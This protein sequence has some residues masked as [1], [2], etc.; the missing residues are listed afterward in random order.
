MN[1][2]A[3][4]QFAA[5][6]FVALLFAA[7][8]FAQT[9]ELHPGTLQ[10]TVSF[11]G[12]TVTRGWLNVYATDASLSGSGSY[13]GSSYSLT[14]EGDHTYRPS[15]INAQFGSNAYLN[16][17]GNSQIA[18]VPVG[19]TA[20]LDLSYT[21]GR[22]ATSI[23]VIGGQLS[24]VQLHAIANTTT[25]SYEAYANYGSNSTSMYIPMV[26]GTQV[27]VVG[28]AYVTPTGSTAAVAQ[29][30]DPQT[31]SLTTAGAAL[32]W[33]VD[34]N[35]AKTGI[36]GS[37]AIAPPDIISNH[38]V[39]AWGMSGATANLYANAAAAANGTYSMYGM[40][41]GQ[42]SVNATTYLKPPYGY[43]QHAN[44]SVDVAAGSV[45]PNDYSGT[46][47]FMHGQATVTGFIDNSKVSSARVEAWEYGS[48]GG[49]ATGTVD[50]NG[51]FHLATTPGSWVPF[52]FSMSIYNYDLAH[53]INTYY[54]DYDY[55]R[56]P[57][58]GAPATNVQAGVDVATPDF[59]INT[60][61]SQIIF[62][63]AEPAGQPEVLISNAR[64]DAWGTRQDASGRWL[65]SRYFYASGP[66]TAQAHPSVTLIGEPGTYSVTASGYV[67][68]SYAT[69]GT[70]AFTLQ[71]PLQTPTGT[72]VSVAP[73]PTVQMT[74]GNV[75]SPGVTTV[76]QS[77]VGPAPPPNFKVLSPGGTPVYYDISTTATFSGSVNVCVHYDDAGLT[78]KKESQLKLYHYN[79]TTGV[80][81]NITN[82]G[83]PDVVNNE[84]C[85]TTSSFS[86]FTVMYSENQPPVIAP[87][88]PFTVTEGGEVTLSV[89]AT[90]ADGDPLTASWDL[91]GDG[92]FTDATGF[93][94]VFSAAN[95]DGPSTRTVKVRVSDG[96]DMTEAGVT[97]NVLNAP[98]VI[99]SVILPSGPVQAS[100]A[101]A[102]TSAAFTDAGRLDTHT[103]VWQWGDGTS[104]AGAV[105]E[106]NGSG[107]AAGSHTYTA[108]GLYT[109]TCVVTDKDGASASAQQ[110]YVVVY[111]PNAGF[112]TGGGFVEPSAGR[113]TFAFNA[114]YLNSATV[115]TGELQIET[116]DIKLH[117][118]AYEWLVINSGEAILKGSN[119][120]YGFLI[121]AMADKIRIKIW[122]RATS[123]V[124]YDT[125]AGAADDAAP[126][127]PTS[128]GSI[129]I[130]K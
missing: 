31:I 74:F 10:G 130:H 21:A 109:V 32:T 1:T 15:Y 118:S 108:A 117:A 58:F 44:R 95:L 52:V 107:S 42:Y 110:H 105:S 77:P 18:Y 25:E 127:T 86:I 40:V 119:N 45:T 88:G 124:V 106:T 120:D 129:N 4:F 5:S 38:Y 9:A 121:S 78:A 36:A 63:V 17:S 69:F 87:A 92:N 81:Q 114:K 66:W 34:L 23:S 126:S 123:A 19:G 99:T 100:V 39:W 53:W 2:R 28:T 16:V 59:T 96:K 104:S 26:A 70:F 11:S 14:V 30:L 122:S 56:T 20:T 37:F 13:T 71:P 54:Y 72:N 7:S 22:I 48:T 24:S 89:T 33:T 98:P 103:A 76:T 60:V 68:G 55:S 91:D 84:L 101:T 49:W 6:A 73:S 80:W 35:A 50:T 64:L 46:L 111:D 93:S 67:N 97:I 79:A 47:G 113:A 116:A 43:L 128:G 61:Q 65:G 90:D 8:A 29:T 85:G 83:S 27:R 112:V 51:M 57:N 102:T 3:L 41:P 125:Q 94:A 75:T 12:E 62:D 82:A 115:P